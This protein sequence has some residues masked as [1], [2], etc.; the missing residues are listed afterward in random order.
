MQFNMIIPS[1][2]RRSIDASHTFVEKRSRFSETRQIRLLTVFF[3]VMCVALLSQR[4]G[5]Q[6]QMEFPRSKKVLLTNSYSGRDWDDVRTVSR[7]TVLETPF[8]RCQSHTVLSE[9]GTSEITDW[10]WFDEKSAVNV[11][12]VKENGEFVVFRQSKYAIK[13]P[14]LS[15]VG[16]LIEETDASPFEAAKREVIEELGLGSSR[17]L[18]KKQDGAHEDQPVDVFIPQITDTGERDVYEEEEEDGSV[19]SDER[20]DW[21]FLGSYRTAANRGG[22]Y[23]YTYLLK[24]AVPVEENGGTNRFKSVGDDEAQR[25]LFMTKDEIRK[26]VMTAQFKEV[27]WTAAMSLALLHLEDSLIYLN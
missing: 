18:L 7:T 26:A 16:G 25:I 17:T 2:M 1:H 21:T 22:G 12:V 14:T 27:K 19:P 8:A 15:P 4:N 11:V 24:N 6:V 5:L 23:T 9:D 20:L 13:G 10:L 3:V